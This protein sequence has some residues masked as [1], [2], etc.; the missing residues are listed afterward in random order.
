MKFGEMPLAEAEGAL[1][2]HGVSGEGFSFRKGRRLDRADIDALARSGRAS[3]VAAHL[4]HDDVAEDEAATAVAR[5][6]AGGNLL[7]S[8]AFTGRANL[9]ATASGLVVY[10]AAALDAVNAV[11]ESITVALLPPYAP[12]AP[13]QMAATV[14]IIPFAAPRG[15]L[16]AVL[17]RVATAAPFLRVAPFQ[18]VRAALIQ[19]RLPG[20]KPSVLAKT[21]EA[22]RARLVA[23]GGSLAADEIVAHENGAVAA[24]LARAAAGGAELLLVLGASAVVDR[25]DVIPSAIVD[26]GGAVHHFGMPVDPGNLLLFGTLAGRP[27]IGLPGCARSPKLNG[28][29]WVLQRVAAGL[30]VGRA[31][32]MRMGAGGLLSEIPTRPL[33]RQSAS[34]APQPPRQPRIAAIVLAAGRSSRMAPANKLL[35]EVDGVAM[36]RRA[37]DAALASQAVATVVV[38]GNDAARVR[39]V[40]DGC[41]ATIVDNPDFAAGLSSSLRA[42]V[43]ALPADLDG[44]LVLLGDMPRV[45]PAHLDRLIAA[46]APAEGRAICIPT[47]RAKRGN[48]ILWDARFLP[49]MR[50][51]DGDQG[52]RGL[53][54]RHADQ[55]CEVEMPDDGVLLDVDTPSALAALGER[56]A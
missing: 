30:P 41:Q 47:H 3:I 55:V 44:V 4:E 37:V 52:A 26:A 24:A 33:P 22:T 35:V 6:I 40:L 45:T 32:I 18:P 43:A 31:E 54:G 15:A 53:I 25:R 10:D 29:D 46:F 36:A 21:V 1:L 20:T 49:E 7:V 14:K 11:D 9:Y 8:A 17:D 50:A 19:T 13:R 51:L 27:V 56:I 48:P 38:L 12:I 42:G 28:F 39:R 5:A 23:L 16:D 34:P 2:A